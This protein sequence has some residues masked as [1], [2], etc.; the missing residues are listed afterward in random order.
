MKNQVVMLEIDISQAENGVL[1]IT[2]D[3][4]GFGRAADRICTAITKSFDLLAIKLGNIEIELNNIAAAFTPAI[5]GMENPAT[6]LSAEG[7]AGEVSLLGDMLTATLEGTA[8]ALAGFGMEKL[9]PVLKTIFEG[10]SGMSGG[11]VAA[12]MAIVAAVIAATALIVT[13]W[14]I[15]KQMLLQGFSEFSGGTEQIFTSLKEN[16]IQPFMES[17]GQICGDLWQKHLQPLWSGLCKAI[18]SIGSNLIVFWNEVVAP[19]VDELSGVFA[20]TVMKAVNAIGGA[21]S[22][23]AGVV[24]DVISGVIK[25]VDGV[26]QFIVGVFTGEWA[27]AWDGVVTIFEG[28]FGAIVGII[29]GVVNGIIFV[30]NTLIGA[31]Y[32][33]VATVINGLGGIVHIIGDIVGEDWRFSV[34]ANPPQIPYLAKGAVLP[35]NRP[36]LAMVGDQRHGTNVEAPLAT[37]QEAVAL[38][39]NDQLSAMMAGFETTVAEVRA[40]RRA[41]DGIQIG[42]ATIGQAAERYQRKMAVVHG[43]Y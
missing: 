27:K 16:I 22:V 18:T 23:L 17:I 14:D 36:F 31:V 21:V 7:T 20:P 32:S 28:V 40:L 43:G 39:M 25:G 37:I 30:I 4:E 2:K 3:M 1:K 41:V 38:V 9:A 11:T 12:V 26:I 19:I 42:D 35:A 34:P 15:C 5:T 10:L 24:A 33:S 13:N 6:A 29:T 8:G